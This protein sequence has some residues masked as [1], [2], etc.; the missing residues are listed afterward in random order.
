MQALAK[1]Y[2]GINITNSIST[3]YVSFGKQIQPKIKILIT[4]LNTSNSCLRK[5]ILDLQKK[6]QEVTLV[7]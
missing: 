5:G 7:L 1:W 2:H 6:S 4:I 3:V